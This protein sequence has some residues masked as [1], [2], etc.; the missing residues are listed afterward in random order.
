MSTSSTSSPHYNPAELD[1]YFSRISLPPKYRDS[2][3]VRNASLAKT[4]EHGLP[5]LSAVMRHQL[6]SVPFENLELHYS[7]H[8]TITLDHTHLFHKIVERNN[9]RGGY[10][11]E[12]NLFFATA[13]K[14]L[15]FE[16]LTCGARISKAIMPRGGRG[17]SG[18]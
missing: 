14:S 12:N 6:A 13:L 8:H 4:L 10:C 17:F 9:G 2:P 11:M 18:W 7:S 15:G 1:L 16:V 3:V 5:F